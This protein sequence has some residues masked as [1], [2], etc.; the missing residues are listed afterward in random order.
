[1]GEK[2]KCCQIFLADEDY[3]AI[4]RIAGR[5]NMSV[6]QW[7]EETVLMARADYHDRVRRIEKVI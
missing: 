7:V 4:E 1:M 6:E 3:A 5:R 2:S